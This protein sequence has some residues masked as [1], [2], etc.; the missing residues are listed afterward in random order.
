MI[1]SVIKE[2][3]RNFQYEG[4]SIHYFVGD[5]IKR[6]YKLLIESAMK[7]LEN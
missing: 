6:N 7:R 4:F 2:K 3:G 1:E 5:I